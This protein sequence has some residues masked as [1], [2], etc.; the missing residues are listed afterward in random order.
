MR[1]AS[2]AAF[3]CGS[4]LLTG[5]RSSSSVLVSEVRAPLKRLRGAPQHGRDTSGRLPRLQ[6]NLSSRRGCMRSSDV[7][8]HI[9]LLPDHETD[10]PPL[11]R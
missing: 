10:Q 4:S 9:V 1:P 11:M 2:G 6:V 3:L 8:I 5:P 7:R